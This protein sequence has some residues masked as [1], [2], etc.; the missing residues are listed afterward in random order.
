[1]LTTGLPTLSTIQAWDVDHLIEAAE[2]WDGTADRWE[3]VSLQVWQ[4]S[5]GLDWE[6]RAR[7]ALVMRT[8][9]DKTTILGKADQLR[10]AAKIARR[11]ASDID[12]AKRRVLYAVEDAHNAGF[13]VGEDL[14]VTDTRTTKNPAQL[15]ARQSQAQVLA[16][17]I[18][19]RTAQLVGLDNEVGTNLVKTAGDVGETN[20][21]EGPIYYGQQP[22]NVGAD[23]RNGTIQ[24]AGHGFK[25]D[26]G[27]PPPPGFVDQYEQQ[28]TSAGPKTP[29]PPI[30]MPSSGPLPP[31]VPQQ[32]G[33]IPPY[34]PPASFG[35]CVGAE[36][37]ANVGKE[38]VKDGFS[39]AIT[40]SIK[41]AIAGGAGGAVLTPELAGTGAIPGA[42]GGG[43][44]GFVG[45][46]VKGL[47]EAP[48]KSGSSA[49]VV[50]L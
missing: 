33:P 23:P 4:Q 15:A 50:G 35:Q 41:G 27:T 21:A 25:L 45:G 11:G 24:L 18:R 2:Y 47:I 5:H 6:G 30:P 9:A 12:A 22:I 37:K 48:L 20:F 7:E 36:V 42:I 17:D 29:P 19:A 40:G 8:T 16:A 39:S 32:P 14:S 26:G 28:L 34:L 38:M 13:T 46:F 44:L 10:E 31:F 3:N 43:V 1:M 49:I